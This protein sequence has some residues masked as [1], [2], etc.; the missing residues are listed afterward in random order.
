M[1]F[2]IRSS[3]LGVIKPILLIAACLLFLCPFVYAVVTEEDAYLEAMNLYN[4]K[5]FDRAEEKLLEFRKNFS[6][7]K[8]MPNVLLKL[9]ELEEDTNKTVEYYVNVMKNYYNSEYEAEAVYSMGRLYYAQGSYDMAEE[10][11]GT[12]LGKYSNTV[13]VEPSY[14]YLMLSLLAKK[15]YDD[16][17]DVYS[18][19]NSNGRYFIFKNRVNLAMANAYSEQEKYEQAADMYSRVIKDYT[20]KEKYIYLPDVY[21]KLYEI[22]MKTDRKSEAESVKEKF[23]TEFPGKGW[24]G[25]GGGGKI[26]EVKEESPK[27]APTKA[28]AGKSGWYY[29]VQVGAFSNKKFAGLMHKKLADKGYEVRIKSG[30]KFHKI[31]V[32]RFETKTEADSFAAEFSR[33]ER[34]NNYLVK[35]EKD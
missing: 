8:Y 21:R 1:K 24:A 28:A 27:P 11:F 10:Y 13:W 33:K 12:M 17:N 4:K 23:K 16:V 35:K 31:Q 2:G 5:E 6:S 7:S 30:G 32:G 19:Y 18:D 29:T 9:A 15:K 26:E 3:E 34:V 20:S 22:Y 14:Y 25:S